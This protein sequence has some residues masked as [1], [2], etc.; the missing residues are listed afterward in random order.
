MPKRLIVSCIFTLQCFVATGALAGNESLA[1]E[2]VEKSGFVETMKSGIN[3]F[4]QDG[5]NKNLSRLTAEI[6]FKAIE[7]IYIRGLAKDLTN[8][9]LS[10]LIK[11]LEVPHLHEALL[12]QGRVSAAI[13]EAIFKE[14]EA[15]GKRAGLVQKAAPELPPKLQKR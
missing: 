9:E 13:S 5:K 8:D 1:R 10:A 3:T 15:A 11:S 7:A 14:I 12:K 4:N 2:Y 6:D